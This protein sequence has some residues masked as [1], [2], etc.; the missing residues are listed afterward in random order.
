MDTDIRRTD[1]SDMI[2]HLEVIAIGIF[3]PLCARPNLQVATKSVHKKSVVLRS[4]RT[5]KCISPAIYV[6]VDVKYQ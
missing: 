3:R 1:F 6:D 4:C 2:C 5:L